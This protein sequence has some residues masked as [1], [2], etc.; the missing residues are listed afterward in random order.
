M[1]IFVNGTEMAVRA[2]TLAALLDELDQGQ[3]KVAT[4]LN[5]EFV[6]QGR[7]DATPLAERD[8]VEIVAARQGG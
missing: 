4:A 8:R 1:I 3:K 2:T 6:A 7:R 5:G